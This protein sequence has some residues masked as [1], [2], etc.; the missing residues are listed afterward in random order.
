MS[1][2]KIFDKKLVRNT[3]AEYLSKYK[4]ECL[5]IREHFLNTPTE[6]FKNMHPLLLL[7]T[8]LYFTEKLILFSNN[9]VRNKLKEIG[10]KE[11]ELKYFIS[12]A[13]ILKEFRN[14]EKGKPNVRI[15]RKFAIMCIIQHLHTKTSYL[16]FRWKE[17][18]LSVEVGTGVKKA[19]SLI[20]NTIRQKR[21]EL[22]HGRRYKDI[23]SQLFHEILSDKNQLPD[24]IGFTNEDLAKDHILGKTTRT[25]LKLLVNESFYTEEKKITKRHFY[26]KIY[27]LLKK[28]IIDDYLMNSD[29]DHTKSGSL[30]SFDS[31]KCRR[32]VCIIDRK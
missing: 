21:V 2:I 8:I 18:I 23:S 28:L 20:K 13:S 12:L 24:E 6:L 16:M 17:E 9:D 29:D 31:Y 1:I 7:P 4:Q 22:V 19:S 26:I 25:W 10:L 32:V 5:K 3:D 15:W 11:N 14:I 30:L 27:D